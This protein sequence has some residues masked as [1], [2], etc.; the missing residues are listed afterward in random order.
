MVYQ[1]RF[2]TNLLQLKRTYEIQN[3][4]LYLLLFL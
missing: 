4:F 1:D 3:G 2:E